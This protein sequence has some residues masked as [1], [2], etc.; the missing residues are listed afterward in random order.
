MSYE[1][2]VEFAYQDWGPDSAI[3]RAI[4]S[5]L[6]NVSTKEASAYEHLTFSSINKL[7]DS[8]LD[9]QETVLLAQYLSGPRV[10][11]LSAGFE[12]ISDSESFILDKDN[13]RFID[14]DNAIEHPRTGEVIENAKESVFMFFSLNAEVLND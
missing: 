3:A 6:K 13:R 11:L 14:T 2:L 12:Y 5:V 10:G 1:K 4:E 8:K 7:A 9:P